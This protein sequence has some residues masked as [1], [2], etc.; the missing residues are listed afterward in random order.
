MRTKLTLIGLALISYTAADAQLMITNDSLFKTAD[1]MLLANELFLSGEPFA[2]ALGYNLDLLDPFTPNV[3]DSISYTTGIEG[4]EYSRYLLGSVISRSGIGLHMM[5]SPMIGMMAAMEPSGFDGTYTG[6]MVNGYTQDDELM[7][8]VGQ[9]TT[10]A[11]QMAPMN[12]FPQF[13]DFMSG[14]THLPQSVAPDF[15]MDFSTLR[16]DRSKMDKTLNPAAMGQTLLKQYYWAQDMLGAYHDAADNTIEADGTITPDSIGNPHFDPNNDVYHGGNALDGFIGQVLTAEGV[17]KTLFLVNQLAYD[18]TAL[19]MVDPATYDPANGIQYFPHKIAVTEEILDPMLPPAMNSLAVTDASSELFDQL[20]YLWGALNFK[21]MMD[22]NINDAAHY[23]YHTV[24]DGDPFPASMQETGMPGPFDLMMGTSKVIFLN[25]LAM[26]YNGVEGTFVSTSGLNGGSVQMGNTVSAFDAGYM[27]VVLKKFV[28]EFTGTPLAPMA[29]SALV[30]Q[31]NYV[32][33]NLHDNTGGYYNGYV[34]GNGPDGS[35]KTLRSQAAVVRGLYAAYEAT[36]DNAYL[37]GANDAYNELINMYY[38]PDQQ[39]FRT[40]YGNAM[41]T[42]TPRDLAVLAGA[43]RNAELIGTQP[44]AAAI[45]T[46]VSKNVYNGM[47]L[48][49]AEESGETGGDSDGDGIPYVAGGTLPFVF[50]A[51]ADYLTGSTGIANADRSTS[52]GLYPNPATTSTTLS[53]DLPAS[54]SVTVN[55]YDLSG[56]L[57]HSQPQQSVSAGT[58]LLHLNLQGLEQGTYFVR[59]LQAGEVVSIDKLTVVR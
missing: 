48:T 38:V 34:I 9:F 44:D 8:M 58:Q 37:T 43:L 30:A 28:E 31:A 27:L 15:R 18:G 53:L 41:A 3:P 13:A 20:S 47:L 35:P 45:Y 49:E 57:A 50:A 6:G 36:G 42:Y 16:W 54:A 52:N 14:N 40:T 56:K 2:E 10:N 24:F 22:P 4:Y 59:V 19:G 32:L 1:Q 33:A 12:P 39:V 29:Q 5:W 7:K 21:N 23:A 17:N 46:R 51:S 25:S 26:H 55:V 11:G